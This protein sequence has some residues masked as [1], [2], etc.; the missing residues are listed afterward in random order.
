MV[1]EQS[2][3]LPAFRSAGLMKKVMQEYFYGAEDEAKAFKTSKSKDQE[4]IRE[5]LGEMLGGNAGKVDFFEP[6]FQLE[7]K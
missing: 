6:M 7:P 3:A 5:I 1:G 2:G 4:L